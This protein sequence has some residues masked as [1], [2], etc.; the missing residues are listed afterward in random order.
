MIARITGITDDGVETSAT[1]EVTL[2]T[3]NI[4]VMA[5]VP[6]TNA[7]FGALESALAMVGPARLQ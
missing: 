5:S 4:T 2:P 3:G 1:A 6:F 7:S